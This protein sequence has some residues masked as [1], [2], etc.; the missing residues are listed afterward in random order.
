MRCQWPGGPRRR[1]DH[2][3]ALAVQVLAAGQAPGQ[4][5][6]LLSLPLTQNP[7]G[8]T[9]QW[10]QTGKVCSFRGGMSMTRRR[11]G[12]L[13]RSLSAAI[14]VVVAAGAGQR[15]V[16]DRAVGAGQGELFGYLGRCAALGQVTGAD[17]GTAGRARVVRPPTAPTAPAGGCRAAGSGVPAGQERNRGPGAP[18]PAAI[19]A[20]ASTARSTS[21]GVLYR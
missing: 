4:A 17:A 15:D 16:R 7:A 2:V 19:A 8:L 11:R 14:R 6:T 9:R 10:M 18:R 21:P 5:P 1:R 20:T 13:A 12:A 3:A